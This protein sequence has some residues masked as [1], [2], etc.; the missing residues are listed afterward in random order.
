MGDYLRQEILKRYDEPFMQAISAL[1]GRDLAKMA[2][3]LVNLTAFL[4]RMT[5]DQD[6]T[7]GDACDGTS[8]YPRRARA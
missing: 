4:T 5:A 1:P 7:I 8:G 6:E 3:V 2:E